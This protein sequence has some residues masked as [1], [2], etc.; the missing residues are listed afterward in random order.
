MAAAA[1]T[2]GAAATEGAVAVG[3]PRGLWAA[4][5]GA[6]GAAVA[7]AGTGG[8]A[9][10]MEPEGAVA[11]EAVTGGLGRCRLR[12]AEVGLGWSFSMTNR[13]DDG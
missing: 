4:A 8:A 2:G 10:T 5:A 7:A 9:A 13:E 3:R 11:G 1:G 12:A 6:D